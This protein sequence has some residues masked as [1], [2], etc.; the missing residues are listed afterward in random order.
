MALDSLNWIGDPSEEYQN[1]IVRAFVQDHNDF[2]RDAKGHVAV[3]HCCV[4]LY[5]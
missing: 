1:F 3:E 5:R 2:A 4:V